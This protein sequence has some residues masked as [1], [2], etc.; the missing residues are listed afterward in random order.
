M[1]IQWL[2]R[3]L[4]LYVVNMFDTY[5]AAKVLGYS[6]L[7]LSYLLN[8][9][10]N[11]TPNKHFQ[12]ADWRIRYYTFR[13][14]NIEFFLSNYYYICSPLPDQ[15][16]S[17]ARE[18]THYLI[19]IYQVLTN[20]LLKNANGKDNLLRSVYQRST[21][22]CKKVRMYYK[23]YILLRVKLSLAIFQI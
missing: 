11:F 5:Q 3:D 15:L 10:C 20:R 17:Y 8:K 16:K 23:C 19:Y 12:L 2:Q 6:G 7:S 18:D 4:S 21:E 13:K 22:I 9:F 14:L 1:D